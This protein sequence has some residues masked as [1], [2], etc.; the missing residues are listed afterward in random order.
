MVIIRVLVILAAGYVSYVAVAAFGAVLVG[1]QFPIWGSLAAG[2]GGAIIAH[3]ILSP[4]FPE[5]R[6]R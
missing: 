1:S 3:L 6:G 2:V 5:K 4:F